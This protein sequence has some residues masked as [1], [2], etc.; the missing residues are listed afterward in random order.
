[1][2]FHTLTTH[3]F[4]KDKTTS[5]QKPEREIRQKK[6]KEQKIVEEEDDNEGDWQKITHKDDPTK[7]L[8]DPKTE[9]NVA[10]VCAKLA[11]IIAQRGRKNTNRKLFVRHLSELY[12]ISNENNLGSGVSAKILSSLISSLFEMNFKPTEAMEY[13]GWSR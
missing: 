13:P 3:T 7:P 11:E 2:F 4:R 5:K 12:D 8:F 6:I 10:V 9:I 1:L